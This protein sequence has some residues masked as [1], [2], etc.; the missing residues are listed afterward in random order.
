MQTKKA[1]TQ[2]TRC[3][4][5]LFGQKTNFRPWILVLIM[6]STLICFHVGFIKPDFFKGLSWEICVLFGQSEPELAADSS[7]IISR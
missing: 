1:T 3:S 7:T 6:N 4:P 5:D 2:V